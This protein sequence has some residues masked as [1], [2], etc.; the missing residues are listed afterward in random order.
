MSITIPRGVDLQYP[1]PIDRRYSKDTLQDRDAITKVTRYLGLSVYVVSEKKS[2]QLVQNTD[3]WEELPTFLTI[4]NKDEF[5][6][7]SA[8]S[9]DKFKPILLN[10]SG[11]ID[12]SM[13]DPSLYYVGPFTPEA[14]DEYP[15]TSAEGDGA[16]WIISGLVAPDSYTYTTGELIGET[17]TNGDHIIYDD[18][19]WTVVDLGVSF[20]VFY[21]RDGLSPIT[22]PFAGGGQ[23]FTNAA[24]GVNPTDLVTVQQLGAI[25]SVTSQLFTPSGST[26][27]AATDELSKLTVFG[28][29]EIT[30]PTGD[31]PLIIDSTTRVN[32][33]NVEYLDGHPASYFLPVTGYNPP[34]GITGTTTSASNSAIKSI[35]Y[36]NGAI[37]SVTS[38][39]INPS[40]IGAATTAHTHT[41]VYMPYVTQLTA[42]NKNFG[43]NHTT[44]AYGD[45]THS[46]YAPFSHN[47]PTLSAGEGL[48]PAIYNAGSTETFELAWGGDGISTLPSRSDHTHTSSE[49][50]PGARTISV[51]WDTWFATPSH[52]YSVRNGNMVHIWGFV[53]TNSNMV[54]DHPVLYDYNNPYPPGTSYFN[55]LVQYEIIPLLNEFDGNVYNLKIYANGKIAFVEALPIDARFYISGSY[56]IYP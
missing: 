25:S 30:K 42:Y 56:R 44:V 8:G 26:V 36:V 43:T 40:S 34:S 17:V 22:A 24:D 11:R 51:A 49:G 55:L 31:A 4:Y 14:G 47:H 12:S 33:L 54:A 20:T 21:R 29:I 27:V 5:I 6:S 32:N 16:Y 37:Q 48:K 45:H 10:E 52:F 15:D 13:V 46:G 35:A 41:G 38:D 50:T 39:V 7:T 28:D 3:T 23:V 9:V 1:E 53:Y 19:S 18:G 2:Y